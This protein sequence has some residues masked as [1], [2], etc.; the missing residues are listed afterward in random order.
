M[1]KTNIVNSSIR[2]NLENEQHLR[3]YTLL[4][5]INDEVGG[6]KNKFIIQALDEYLKGAGEVFCGAKKPYENEEFLEKVY[7]RTEEAVLR[8]LG[9]FYAGGK[10]VEQMIRKE[11]EGMANM[12]V[13]GLIDAWNE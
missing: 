8:A 12:E 5:K 13:I 3:V 7:E 11:D 10:S 1:A 9:C 6:S 4:S 2:F